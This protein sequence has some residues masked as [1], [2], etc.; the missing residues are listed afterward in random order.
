MS[1]L[2]ITIKCYTSKDISIWDD[3]VEKSK[4]GTFLFKRAYM[5]YHAHR[6]E[7]F[8]LMVFENKKLIA[9]L[10]ANRNEKILYSHQGLTYGSLLV[11]T[12]VSQ[13][14]VL[15]IFDE[16]K[17]FLKPFDFEKIYY[18]TVPSIYHKLPCEEDL[19][20]LFRNNA[21]LV[22]RNCSTTFCMKKSKPSPK[23]RLS[24]VL[25]YAEKHNLRYEVHSNVD[26]FWSIVEE[27]LM[28]KHG[29]SPVHSQAEI[30]LLKSSFPHN[31]Q[32]I[33][34]YSEKKIVAG[35][36]VYLANDAAH[37]QYVG[38]SSEGEKMYA[39]E[40]LYELFIHKLFSDYRYFDFGISTEKG[41]QFLNEGLISYKEKFGGN[42]IV[43]DHY[44][45]MIN[46]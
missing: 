35:G 33:A 27:N 18:K 31:I 8:S 5:D 34:V 22:V 2:N 44:E 23:L 45:I 37:L 1:K 24:R 46:D 13:S 32:A 26:A 19:Y 15:G 42:T 25:N 6:F 30:N 17:T 7:D 41:G 12:D 3:F 11:S 16:L 4:N 21:K 14:L 20:A 29:T 39:G 9:L 36:V 43:Y 10:P 40:Y 28:K 38:L